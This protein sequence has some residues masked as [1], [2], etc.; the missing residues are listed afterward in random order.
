VNSKGRSSIPRR[1]VA[2]A[3]KRIE[4]AMSL[5]SMS[6]S[7]LPRI[8]CGCLSN[9][10]F[11]KLDTKDYYSLQIKTIGNFRRLLVIVL[12]QL[13]DREGRLC[14]WAFP[15]FSSDPKRLL[16]GKKMQQATDSEVS[17]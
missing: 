5:K 15:K 2:F 12:A 11:G 4:P 10:V 13:L 17:R 14:R 16:G 6:R 9:F 1:I 8:P 3:N 7:D